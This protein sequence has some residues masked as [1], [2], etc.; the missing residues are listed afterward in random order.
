MSECEHEWIG[1]RTCRKC[2]ITDK[3]AE[4][5]ISDDFCAEKRENR[6]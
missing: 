1:S 4:E 6:L 5:M 3:Y 2:G